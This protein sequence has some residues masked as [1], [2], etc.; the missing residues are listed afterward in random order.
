MD[1]DSVP[2]TPS[3]GPP[4]PWRDP[5][6]SDLNSNGASSQPSTRCPEFTPSN[7]LSS[8]HPSPSSDQHSEIALGMTPDNSEVH[9]S[10]AASRLD[11]LLGIL[12]PVKY[13]LES[14]E[15]QMF[16]VFELELRADTILAGI[17]A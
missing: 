3:D 15:V 2:M 9:S 11:E 16:G 6:N 8:L 4:I 5:F 1:D 12:G 14:Y 7:Q 10:A 17:H 13:H